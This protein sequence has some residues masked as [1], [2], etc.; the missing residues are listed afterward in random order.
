MGD[1]NRAAE[2]TFPQF[3]SMMTN[4]LE[5]DIP[6]SSLHQVFDPCPVDPEDDL[7]ELRKLADVGSALNIWMGY[8]LWKSAIAEAIGRLVP[9]GGERTL[10]LKILDEEF[11]K[12]DP[13]RLGILQPGEAIVL[14]YR[15]LKP[16]LTCAD[17]KVFCQEHLSLSIPERELHR[18]FNMLDINGDGVLQAE[19]FIPFFRYLMLDFFPEHVLR[20]MN[21]STGKI[22]VF[23]LG[24]ITLL[25][26]V[27]TLIGV[28]VAAFATAAGVGSTIHSGVNGI[29]AFGAK[30]SSDAGIGFEGSMQSLKK[31]LDVLV[32][33]AIATVT[34]ISKEVT[35]KLI[36]F[37][38]MGVTAAASVAV[39]STVEPNAKA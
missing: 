32:L 10:A 16:G 27:F 9:R 5:I 17:M 11:E 28:V 4:M 23:V 8:G 21:I 22:A 33:T 13:E 30:Q 2:C 7:A 31:E 19:E 34:G 3:K 39:A 14:V 24:L 1:S 38:T 12:L 36:Q 18:Y 35:D 20:Q 26:L 25:V 37:V 15:L 29:M 6:D